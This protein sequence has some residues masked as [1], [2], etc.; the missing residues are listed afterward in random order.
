MSGA[1]RSYGCAYRVSEQHPGP[2]LPLNARGKASHRGAAALNSATAR[3]A[4]HRPANRTRPSSLRGGAHFAAVCGGSTAQGSMHVS[5]RPLAERGG[6]YGPAHQCA[7][8][9]CAV[10]SGA[11][12]GA[13]RR[14]SS[15]C[16]LGLRGW[17]MGTAG[18][19]GGCPAVKYW[20]CTRDGRILAW[21][22][23]F[24]TAHKGEPAGR[25]GGRSFAHAASH[26]RARIMRTHRDARTHH[27]GERIRKAAKGAMHPNLVAFFF[28]KNKS[29][30]INSIIYYG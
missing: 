2:L 3:P 28:I 18:F 23:V 29:I 12:G 7:W 22:L 17:A 11:A 30:S 1:R 14:R 9:R 4:A 6:N 8:Q 26:A 19:T 16:S 10:A 13:T 15:T 21:I 24:P 25:R 27:H 20:P 5:L